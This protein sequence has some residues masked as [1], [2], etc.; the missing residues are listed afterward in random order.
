MR[1]LVNEGDVNSRGSSK[2]LQ[3]VHSFYEA[4]VGYIIA[5]FPLKDDILLNARV[6]NF[7]KCENDKFISVESFLERYSIVCLLLV[8]LKK[9]SI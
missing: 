8:I 1:A 5:K 9:K 2:F 3:S 6:I 7:K 4:A